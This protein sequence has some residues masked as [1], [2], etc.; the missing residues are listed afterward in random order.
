[1]SR[2]YVVF[3]VIRSYSDTYVTEYVKWEI[4]D[5]DTTHKLVD[6]ETGEFVAIA[7][8][9]WIAHGKFE[10]W[11]VPLKGSDMQWILSSFDLEWVNDGLRLPKIYR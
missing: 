6:L 2:E 10:R 7:E 5:Y 9:E 8:S 1:M 11:Q 4:F 3:R